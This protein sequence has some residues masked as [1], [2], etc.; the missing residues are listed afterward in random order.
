MSTGNGVSTTNIDPL[1]AVDEIIGNSKIKGS[2][3]IKTAD[4]AKQLL[5]DSPIKEAISSAAEGSVQFST[6]SQL[7]T[8]A[9][10]RAGQPARVVGPDEGNH[11]DPVVG[12]SVSNLG[13]YSWST[14][15]A[16]WRWL[17]ELALSAEGVTLEVIEAR[18]EEPTLYDAVTSKAPLAQTYGA[19]QEAA[20][21]G[22]YSDVYADGYL[23]TDAK[24][25]L[26][27]FR[28][29]GTVDIA[30][31]YPL[32]DPVW[33]YAEVVETGAGVFGVVRGWRRDGTFYPE[34]NKEVAGTVVRGAG[35]RGGDVS[36]FQDGTSAKITFDAAGY[37]DPVCSGDFCSYLDGSNT[38]ITEEVKAAVDFASGISTCH[39]I[40]ISGQSLSDGSFSTPRYTVTP[41]LPGKLVSFNA[42][43]RT[44]GTTGAWVLNPPENLYALKNLVEVTDETPAA[45]LGYVFGSSLPETDGVLMS[46]HGRGS[47][48][49]TGL[50][51]GTVPYANMIGAVRRARVICSL[52]KI[53][54]EARYVSFIHGETDRDK[55]KAVYKGYMLEFQGDLTTDINAAS[56][57]SGDVILVLD[58][59]SNW[60]AFNDVA[61]S[62]IP[63]AQLEVALENSAK[64]LCVGPK[65]HLPT[66]ADGVHLT[67][68]SS[69]RLGSY[70]GRMIARHKAGQS[71]LPLHCAS[72]ARSGAVV[73]LAM[74][75]PVGPLILDTD[76]VT[77]PGNY[78]IVWSQTG[79][80]PRTIQSV[81]ISGTNLVVTLDG[82]PG[83]PTSASISVAMNGATGAKGGPT[84]GPRSCLRDS[85]TDLDSA[86]VPMPNWACHQ[87][88][89]L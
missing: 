2:G 36:I 48:F 1:S 66:V 52:K 82:D 5:A 30:D 22:I 64:I 15:P 18:G 27:G 78:G 58:Q 79:G 29:D 62:A 14:S 81:A 4:F 6:W 67:N 45:G 34:P 28:K 13:E 83:T 51:K 38:E 26:L 46:V 33:L 32:L 49:Y 59:T 3:R 89:S 73:T 76:A 84:T 40:L 21:T 77:D 55:T 11:I 19:I 8:I 85:A 17:R 31:T 75:V 72:A 57:G 43:P 16:G 39:H 61:T 35:I 24:T 60:T 12:G 63:A 65:Y 50:K 69:R 87:T 86:G 42:G 44:R 10:T 37:S 7:Q 71:T 23:A 80:T 54:Y 47:Q 41:Q 20:G 74:H 9:G 70:H 88:I 68:A 56:G 25:V 53:A